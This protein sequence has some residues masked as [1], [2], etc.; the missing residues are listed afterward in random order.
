[1]PVLQKL[2]VRDFRNIELQELDF[3]PNINC[4]SGDN[5]E[6]KTNLLEAIWYLSM[7]KASQ[8]RSDRFCYRYGTD[9][10]SVSG[11]C[12]MENGTV[13]RFSVQSQNGEKKV[14]RDGKQYDRISEHIGVLPVVMVSP[15][16]ISL[17]SDSG[18][19][20]R[21]FVNTVL[22][23]MDPAYLDDMQHYNHLLASRNTALK[24]ASPDPAFL[25]V[26]DSRMAFYASDIYGKR[27]RFIEDLVPVVSRYYGLL[28]SE[29]ESVQIEY[30]SDLSR[31]DLRTILQDSR[32]KDRILGFT[33]GG[34]HRDDFIF[35]MNGHPIRK[36]GS[37]G[38][39]KSFLVSLKFAQYEIMKRRY[40]FP[41][42]LLLDDL[43]DKLDMMR[44]S[45]LL[46]M[47]SGNDFGQ[48]FLTDSNKVR[49]DSLLD[50][51]TSDRHCFETK[52]GVF[53]RTDG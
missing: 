9:A 7:T 16:D 49:I 35:T 43:F 51:I 11:I 4:I 44:V 8:G 12:G 41:P 48:I 29:R 27:L 46:E 1:M 30:R 52:G 23:Q 32:E 21:R 25:D 36:Y 28:S 22:S 38:Q 31:G 26:V 34:I 13:S 14:R 17:V 10:L 39:Q 50:G 6:G 18:D 19:E 45:N 5:G 53:T 20:R 24:S 15:S 3:S 37:Q 42:L 47:V 2:F 33:S 40:G